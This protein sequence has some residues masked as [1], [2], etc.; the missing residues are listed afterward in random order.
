MFSWLLPQLFLFSLHSV[1]T[2]IFSSTVLVCMVSL[3]HF[4]LLL[5]PLS[6]LFF[7]PS[8]LHSLLFKLAC[9]QFLLYPKFLLAFFFFFSPTC[10]SILLSEFQ[11]QMSLF[12][13]FQNLSYS[14]WSSRGRESTFCSSVGGRKNHFQ[15]RFVGRSREEIIPLRLYLFECIDFRNLWDKQVQTSDGIILK[16]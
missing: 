7:F 5:L 4:L 1:E 10:F 2:S 9:M 3:C 8:L 14:K 11:F 6:P 16:K 13:Q 12:F 15:S